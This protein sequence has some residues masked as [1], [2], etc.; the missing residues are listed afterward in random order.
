[1]RG[2]PEVGLSV[3]LGVVPFVY[4]GCGCPGGVC[5][6]SFRNVSDSLNY[7][8]SR[9]ENSERLDE[10]EKVLARRVYDFVHSESVRER[11]EK[12]SV[13]DIDYPGVELYEKWGLGN[14]KCFSAEEGAYISLIR[15][16][17]GYGDSGVE[18]DRLWEKV[19]LLCD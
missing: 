1:M 4:S 8:Y 13:F 11:I 10:S 12:R 2:F 6:T 7:F 16:M 18:D 9:V 17:D 14:K 15:W 5:R 3:V 19:E